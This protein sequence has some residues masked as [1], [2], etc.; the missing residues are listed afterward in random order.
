[1]TEVFRVDSQ[2]LATP[3]LAENL[4]DYFS[5]KE[6]SEIK[7]VGNLIRFFELDKCL[8]SNLSRYFDDQ[9]APLACG[10][11]SPCRS[12]FAKLF[13]SNE[14]KWPSDSKL[15]EQLQTLKNHLQN[16]SSLEISTETYSRFLMGLNA[17]LF[18]RNKVRKIEGFGSCEKLPYLELRAK[19]IEL[20]GSLI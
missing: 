16:K 13:A 17:P 15:L 5:Q 9:E 20:Q 6:T 7:R 2:N 3:R 1:M 19:V 4:Y 18:T 8:N 11:C 12:D 10:H 14:K